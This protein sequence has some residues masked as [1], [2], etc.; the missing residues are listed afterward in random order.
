PG[1]EYIVDNII[2][3]SITCPGGSVITLPCG[4][5]GDLEAA[6]LRMKTVGADCAA[7]AIGGMDPAVAAAIFKHD[8]LDLEMKVDIL[9]RVYKP[10]VVH[11]I[12]RRLPTELVTQIMVFVSPSM[13]GSWLAHFSLK[14]QQ[15]LLGGSH[16][17]VILSKPQQ[18][19]ILHHAQCWS[20]CKNLVSQTVFQSW[21]C[22]EHIKAFEPSTAAKMLASMP[23]TRSVAVLSNMSTRDM[24][25]SC[26]QLKELRT[27]GARMNRLRHLYK[28]E[29]IVTYRVLQR[30][31]DADT[32]VELREEASFLMRH[33][34]EAYGV[35]LTL[36]RLH[37]DSKQAPIHLMPAQATPTLRGRLDTVKEADG[38]E[39][40]E[41]DRK[42]V[43]EAD[44]SLCGPAS[45]D[46][47]PAGSTQSPETAATT[48]KIPAPIKIRLNPD[49]ASEVLT[50]K[51]PFSASV[52]CASTCSQISPFW[53]GVL[54]LHLLP[55]LP[56][57]ARHWIRRAPKGDRRHAGDPATL[58]KREAKK[59]ERHQQGA[60]D[61][62]T[63]R[64][65]GARE[66]P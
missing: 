10:E 37:L 6:A 44:G 56:L 33:F 39:M 60:E 28:S 53:L 43:D 24:T 27:V 42:Q 2:P 66:G 54:R 11:Q 47:P 9:R 36:C 19:E 41:A 31:I 52:R 45:L 25:Q 58:W 18:L 49:V 64:Q 38:F 62:Q 13:A 30:L 59:S 63:M 40:D 50:P 1:D 17:M 8:A 55:N 21:K 34:Q 51:S 3:E 65:G 57:L 48:P 4:H 46:L 20:A 26:T 16:G 61:A 14:D 29:D 32:V 22:T 12:L 7:V 35:S 23:A 5:N 15:A